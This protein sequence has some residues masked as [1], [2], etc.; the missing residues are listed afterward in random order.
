MRVKI[1]ETYRRP[2][3]CISLIIF[4][5]WSHLHFVALSFD[6]HDSRC[7]IC[8]P[9]AFLIHGWLLVSFLVFYWPRKVG[10]EILICNIP[11]NGKPISK[12]ESW[13][14]NVL[15]QRVWIFRFYLGFLMETVMH[16]LNVS[17]SKFFFSQ[18][19]EPW[20]PCC[21]LLVQGMD[22]WCR[23]RSMKRSIV[24]FRVRVPKHLRFVPVLPVMGSCGK[25]EL[26]GQRQS[27]S[28][29]KWT[30]WILPPK[31]AQQEGCF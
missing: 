18:M 16:L 29:N 25:L 3:F 26:T 19:L 7:L 6:S 4:L 11:K 31:L 1:V 12:M 5:V 10:L 30:W 21:N 8:F 13:K 17:L 24:R 20:H 28:G 14:I 23:K 15:L 2:I 27:L 9:I 22:L